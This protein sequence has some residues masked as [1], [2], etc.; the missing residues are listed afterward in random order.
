MIIDESKLTQEQIKQIKKWIK[1]KVWEPNG[2]EMYFSIED[3]GKCF[4]SA[5]QYCTDD[6]L[7]SYIGNCFRTEEEAHEAGLYF[8]L[9]KFSGKSL[10]ER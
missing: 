2:E 10:L 8:N 3:N 6:Y 1:P 4:A 5:W 7:R 9:K